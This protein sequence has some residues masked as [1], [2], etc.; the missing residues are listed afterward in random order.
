MAKVTP[1]KD[2]APSDD[3]ADH[4]VQIAILRERI[5]GMERAREVQIKELARRL[6]ELNH[7][8]ANAV[9]MQNTYLPREV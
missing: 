4:R 5:A 9:K 2:T 1:E 8:H 6:D 7:A 3:D